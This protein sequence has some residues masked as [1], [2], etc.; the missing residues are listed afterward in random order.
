MADDDV[1]N[2]DTCSLNSKVVVFFF[3]NNNNI[4][5]LVLSRPY[6][7]VQWQYIEVG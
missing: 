5:T 7:S 3:L 2:I 6:T 1:W 4:V